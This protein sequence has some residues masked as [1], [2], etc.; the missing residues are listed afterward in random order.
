ML[1]TIAIPAHNKASYLQKAIKSI[2]KDDEFGKNVN[3]VI[4]DNSNNPEI[5]NLYERYYINNKKISYFSSKKYNCLDSNVNR[6]IQLASGK[7][8]SGM[9]RIKMTISKCRIL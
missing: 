6:S 7:Y 5:K 9:N 1:L 4:S 3:I 2:I 8:V